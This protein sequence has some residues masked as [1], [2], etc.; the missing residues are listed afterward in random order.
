MNVRS[1]RL[2]QLDI[3][4]SLSNKM[5]ISLNKGLNSTWSWYIWFYCN[6]SS[7]RKIKH[8]RTAWKPRNL[9]LF[10]RQSLY[11]QNGDELGR[12]HHFRRNR[13]VNLRGHRLRSLCLQDRKNPRWFPC[14]MRPLFSMSGMRTHLQTLPM[15]ERLIRFGRFLSCEFQLLPIKI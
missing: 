11:H 12:G 8:K 10:W 5:R 7:Y 6:G 1:G 13:R 4:H 9:L 15:Q 2:I 3:E 14:S